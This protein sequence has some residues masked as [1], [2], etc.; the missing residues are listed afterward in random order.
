MNLVALADENL[1]VF[2]EYPFLIFEN[3]TFTNKQLLHYANRLAKGLRNLN[4]RKGDNASY[5]T[6]PCC[7]MFQE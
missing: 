5:L 1:H 3:K 2:G 6:I 4:V 7:I